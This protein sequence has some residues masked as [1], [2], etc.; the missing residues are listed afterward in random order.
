MQHA[1][2]THQLLSHSQIFQSRKVVNTIY[3]L[4][5]PVGLLFMFLSPFFSTR[6][7]LVRTAVTA[8]FLTFFAVMGPDLQTYME[9]QMATLATQ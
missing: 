1:D 8:S 5:P 2:L 6:E 7:R 9:V 3:L 4:V